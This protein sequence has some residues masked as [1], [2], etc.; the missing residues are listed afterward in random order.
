[1]IAAS[2]KN[3]LKIIPGHY[4]NVT[5]SDLAHDLTVIWD[6]Q[7]HNQ[8]NHFTTDGRSLSESVRLGTHDQ[9]LVAVKTVSILFVMVRPPY[10]EDGSIL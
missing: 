8:N 7:S 6:S 10:R 3:R 2:L 4:V 1:M 5:D 9:I